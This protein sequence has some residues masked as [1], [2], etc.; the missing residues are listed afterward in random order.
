VRSLLPSWFENA[1]VLVVDDHA[2]NVLLLTRVLQ[3]AGI[4]T[5]YGL[6]D[7][8]LVVDQCMELRPDL[9]LLDWHMPHLDGDAVLEA[10][11]A[12]YPPDEF[13]PVLVLTADATPAARERALDAGAKDFVAKPFDRVEVVQRVRNLL[14]TQALYTRVRH[15]NLILQAELDRQSDD[16]R[17]AVAERDRRRTV[18]ET[19][20][21]G[22]AMSMVFQPIIDLSSSQV[23]GAE[24]LA[25]FDCDPRRPPDQWFAEAT[26][27]GL[28]IE[29]EMAAVEAAI[30]TLQELPEQ[31]ALSINASGTTA[32]SDAFV[33]AIAPVA[34]DRIVIELT[35]HA[36]I[37][38]YAAFDPAV[39]GLRR[40]GVRLAV[41][42]AGAGYAGLQQILGLRPD[43]IKLDAALTR[44]ID[45]DPV[46][47]ALA[48]SLVSFG[49]DTD[50]VIVAEGIETDDELSTLRALGVPWGQ[51]FLLAR[52]APL[53]MFLSRLGR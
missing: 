23:V 16:Q 33:D 28:G 51:G 22:D 20:L 25:R 41:D 3:T 45:S 12:T 42:D 15:H 32:V 14:E 52:P 6:T 39:A 19:I 36:R 8:R 18:I 9:L 5:V 2:A 50:A 1:T 29:L 13:L 48:A 38:D 30:G 4:A 10:L 37:E 11:H 7:A 40:L 47:R 44:D 31:M 34:S 35:E 53:P 49:E 43:V 21:A 27:V 46:R 17:K 24:A 26:L